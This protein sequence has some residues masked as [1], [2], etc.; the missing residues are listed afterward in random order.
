MES[1]EDLKLFRNV[2]AAL[3]N[4]K[5]TF[6]RTWDIF[7]KYQLSNQTQNLPFEGYL[8]SDILRY[9]SQW[10]NDKLSQIHK[11]IYQKYGDNWS[12]KKIKIKNEKIYF[13]MIQEYYYL[14]KIF[15][16]QPPNS[17]KAQEFVKELGNSFVKYLYP[18]LTNHLDLKFAE[19]TR[20][21]KEVGYMIEMVNFFKEIAPDANKGHMEMIIQNG[22]S[23]II[24]KS[25]VLNKD[26][27]AFA[28]I[29][30]N[31]SDIEF[32]FIILKGI[33]SNGID[34][35]ISIYPQE[36]FQFFN[37]FLSKK[38]LII[39]S[40][41]IYYFQIL[42]DLQSYIPTIEV[43]KSKFP[44]EISFKTVD[45]LRNDFSI[46]NI[47]ASISKLESNKSIALSF[48]KGDNIFT[49]RNIKIVGPSLYSIS[50][51]L[52]KES[53]S[54]NSTLIYQISTNVDIQDPKNNKDSV[55][56]SVS[57]NGTDAS[58]KIDHAYI[59]FRHTKYKG[60]GKK[61]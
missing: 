20:F 56:F 18:H 27:R 12:K 8:I 54:F 40:D 53:I 15:Q 17:I 61:L 10:N 16:N 37:W 22:L 57:I 46:D 7:D 19:F 36:W 9:S 28:T 11:Q 21:T 47:T 24:N 45:Y 2:I 52:T 59:E 38:K 49:T 60:K 48:T 5:G 26:Q 55:S 42:T 39:N 43:I 50:L 32:N 23:R 13:E 31:I 44:E 1:I 6:A 4:L 3:S 35:I 30:Q 29:D 33:F 34:K 41:S 58:S 25:F 14:M 51:Q